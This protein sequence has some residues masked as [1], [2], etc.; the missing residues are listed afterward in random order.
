M[1]STP[2]ASDDNRYLS[3]KGGRIHS[4]RRRSAHFSKLSDSARIFSCDASAR[5]ISTLR[6]SSDSVWKTKISEGSGE[7]FDLNA[8]DSKN[9]SKESCVHKW[10]NL[11]GRLFYSF[12]Y[13]SFSV[14]LIHILF[15]T[16]SLFS[17]S[18]RPDGRTSSW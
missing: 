17:S 15:Q 9:I 3:E 12:I 8:S 4:P 5:T 2:W 14:C 18:C 6:L 16:Q 13:P 11:S 7:A 1:Y 10:Q